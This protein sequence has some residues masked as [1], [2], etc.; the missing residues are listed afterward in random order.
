MLVLVIVVVVVSVFVLV[1]SV[2]SCVL[3]GSLSIF[4]RGEPGGFP[5]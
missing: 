5:A 4:E 3:S 2:A 1:L